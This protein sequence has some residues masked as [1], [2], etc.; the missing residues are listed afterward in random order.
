MTSDR[1]I[2]LVALGLLF[3]GALEAAARGL[4]L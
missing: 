2:A 4:L 1:V 3:Y